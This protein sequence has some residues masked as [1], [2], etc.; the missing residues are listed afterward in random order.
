MDFV[1]SSKE[2]RSRL[3]SALEDGRKITARI[4]WAPDGLSYWLHCTPLSSIKDGG[5]VWVVIFLGLEDIVQQDCSVAVG[6][7]NPLQTSSH[8]SWLVTPW[9]SISSGVDDQDKKV[10]THRQPLEAGGRHSPEQ[11]PLPRFE[12]EGVMLEQ[13][14][15]SCAIQNRVQS[16]SPPLTIAESESDHSQTSKP[17]GL[18]SDVDGSRARRR[19][20]KSLSPYGVLF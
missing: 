12:T 15:G 9:D 6:E 7:D 8:S 10:F 11:R 13:T 1:S 16:I 4:K 20:Y 2:V 3:I 5:L 17:R 18:R 14:L 19:T